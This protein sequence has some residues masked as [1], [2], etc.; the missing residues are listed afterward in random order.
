MNSLGMR[1]LNTVALPQIR[2]LSHSVAIGS[3][4]EVLKGQ[5]DFMDFPSVHG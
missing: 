2:I 4:V 3:A 1:A 5:R